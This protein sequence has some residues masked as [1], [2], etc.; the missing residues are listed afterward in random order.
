M[1]VPAK[2]EFATNRP[3]ERV[4]DAI[5][6]HLAHLHE[7]LANPPELA[8]ASAYFNPGGYELLADELDHVAKVRLLI[9]AEPSI[10][11]RP[12]RRLADSTTPARAARVQLRRALEG[13]ARTLVEDR[14]L[15]G[16][17]IEA[18][19]GARRLVEWLRS[20]KV[21]VRRLMSAP[22]RFR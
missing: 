13:H 18:D 6:A 2:P 17:T 20:G 8:I 19:R 10:P 14:D 21:E 4:A 16:F 15:L 3:G 9:G 12:L 22:A 7:T 1:S 11:E 5:C